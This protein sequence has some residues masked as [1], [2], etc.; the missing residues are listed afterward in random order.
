MTKNIFKVQSFSMILILTECFALQAYLHGKE[1]SSTQIYSSTETQRADAEKQ[2]DAISQDIQSLVKAGKFQDAEKLFD[3][4]FK[5]YS[6]L[7]NTKYV[8][9]KL[10]LLQSKKTIFYKNWADYIEN[11]ATNAYLNKEWDKS[12]ALSKQSMDVIKKIKIDNPSAN[13]KQDRIMTE[14]SSAIN[15]ENFKTAISIDTTLPEYKYRIKDLEDSINKAQV[16]MKQK[17]YQKAKSCLEEALLLDPYNYKAMN[18]LNTLYTNLFDVAKARTQEEDI[19]AIAQVQWLNNQPVSPEITE[20]DTLIVKEAQSEKSSKIKEKLENIILSK[21][22][23]DNASISS[24]LTYLNRESKILDTSGDHN[25]INII[26]KLSG[27][28]KEPKLVT[29]QLDDMPIGEA[30]KYVCLAT[31]LKYRI[32]DQAVVIGDSSIEQMETRY[33]QTQSGLINSI[34]TNLNPIKT[35]LPGTGKSN[36]YDSKNFSKG[37]SLP[38]QNV[39]SAQLM[40]YF[41]QRGVPLPQGSSIAWDSK[42]SLLIATNTPDNQKII[43]SLIKEIDIQIPLVLIE[44]KFVEITEDEL[45]ELSF[46]WK[47]SS[48]GANGGINQFIDPAGVSTLGNDPI[49]RPYNDGTGEPGALIKNLSYTQGKGGI[50]GGTSIQ[51]WMYALDQSTTAEVLSSPKV[52]T[53]SGSKAIIKMVTEAYYPQTWSVP[54]INT[55]AGN[56]IQLN[57][58]SP[59]FGDPTDLGI[60]LEVTPTVSPNNHTILL[61]VRP[62]VIDFVDW[63]NYPYII[64]TSTGTD[65]SVVEVPAKMA[66]IS[67]RDVETKVKVYDGETVVLGGTIKEKSTY[68][69]DE[70]PFLGD[71]PLAGR[72]F[73]SK[74]EKTE[75]KNLLIFVTARLVTPS[76]EPLRKQ[77]NGLF[78]FGR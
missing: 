44:T 14:A 37:S 72:L 7:G 30:I 55:T 56:S 26:L 4:I 71:I 53:K 73:K 67:H 38:Q 50:F 74:Y 41:K 77:T 17:E 18:M 6:S 49:V 42:T 25:G 15:N 24:V 46:K 19:K 21:I 61:D 75:R 51:F 33:Y 48:T 68:V 63:I 70:M 66:K 47:I 10:S 2:A 11:Q 60:I 65:T 9:L 5:I 45:E 64:T 69:N 36:F 28:Q 62:Q 29:I 43:N 58:S 35:D 32:E 12:I 20:K 8:S 34:V 27:A 13:T 59:T 57:T 23:F 1:P 22:D 16:Y 54:T 3:K 39:T 78:D 31:G 76:G 40:D 52:T